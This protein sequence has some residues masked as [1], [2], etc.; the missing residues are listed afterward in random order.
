MVEP[1]LYFVLGASYF[2]FGP[3]YWSCFL[4]L[5]VPFVVNLS[6]SINLID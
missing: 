2:G 1:A 5:L 4:C 3:L 6:L